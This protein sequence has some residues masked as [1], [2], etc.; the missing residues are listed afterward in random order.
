MEGFL[1]ANNVDAFGRDYV[2]HGFGAG[3]DAVAL[4]CVG[5]GGGKRDLLLDESN[6]NEAW[7]AK[8]FLS[9]FEAV[10]LEIEVLGLCNGESD[11]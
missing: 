10:C 2:D 6:A 8:L 4:I 1:K 7:Y 5:G 9:C 3:E 11:V